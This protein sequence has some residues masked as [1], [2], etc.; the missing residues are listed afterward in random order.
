MD[1]ARTRQRHLF[2]PARVL[3]PALA[4]AAAAGCGDDPAPERVGLDTPMVAAS[5]TCVERGAATL[6]GAA[7]DG[8]AWIVNGEKTQLVE[9]D[10]T[11][12]DAEWR[13]DDADRVLPTGA[14]TASLVVD[15]ELWTI[16]DG[17]REFVSVPASA[18]AASSLCGPPTAEHGTFVATAGGLI[19]RAGGVWWQWAPSRSSSFGPLRELIRID[20]ACAAPDDAV[21]L[22][23][24]GGELWRVA[25][26]RT[27]IVAGESVAVDSVAIVPGEGA[28]AL[29]AG[30]LQLGP[31]WHDVIFDAGPV[32][33]IAS[34][35]G[36]LWVVA[37]GRTY[38]RTD[39][40]WTEVTGLPAAPTALH[41]DAL[42]GAWF[43]AGTQACRA[44]LTPAIQIAGVNP[45]EPRLE[46]TA[47]LRITPPAD[48]AEV[49]IERDGTALATV[50]VVDGVAA[51][52]VD[53]GD[54]GW[55]AL[56]VRAG[57]ASRLLQ[58][59]LLQISDRS[60]ATDIAP[61]FQLYCS[62]CHGE[63]TAGTRG[64]LSTYEAWRGKAGRIRER[65]LRGEMPPSGPRPDS[66][67]LE[68]VLD[69]IEGGM[70][71]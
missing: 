46:P 52:S 43:D 42:G 6:I 61:V 20:G 29:T 47:Q 70:R 50:P 1:L 37:G 49:T 55:H 23:G 69:W 65:M 25:Q 66:A 8:Q 17:T 36:R 13:V 59:N 62:R 16:A 38:V 21:W 44:A 56:T 58:Y 7:H 53:L 67:T 35:G 24:A 28:A 30:E 9:F 39:G 32:T 18:G 4:L 71:P 60:W 11:I 51:A 63:T 40:A 19:E 14:G 31:P 10:G 5:V 64:D 41:P 48:T 57:A 54:G 2:A 27:E 15:G 68:I 3:A 45:F 22:H 12:V 34:G 26:D 33:A